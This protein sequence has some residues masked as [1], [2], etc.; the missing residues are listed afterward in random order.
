MDMVA[1]LIGMHML[2]ASEIVGCRVVVY[3][4]YISAIAYSGTRHKVRYQYPLSV[5]INFLFVF[6]ALIPYNDISGECWSMNE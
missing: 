6:L 3:L 5:D 1:S 4:N 2:I